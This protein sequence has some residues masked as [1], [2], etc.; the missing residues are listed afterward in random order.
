GVAQGTC[1]FVVYGLTGENIDVHSKDEMV[2]SAIKYM[3]LGGKSLGIG[4]AN[5][6]ASIYNNPQLYPQAF[7]W[8][9]PYGLGGIGNT[10]GF[11]A[12]PEV[13]RQRQLLMY[14]D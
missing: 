6:L 11:H 13:H 10:R 12:V 1:P 8:L 9:F 3:E 14:H 7:P 4:T 5:H 2:T